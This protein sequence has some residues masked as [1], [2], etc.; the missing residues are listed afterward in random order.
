M[1]RAK[2]T[3]AI[4]NGGRGNRKLLVGVSLDR[5]TYAAV[6]ALAEQR[7][8]SRSLWCSNAI[9]MALARATAELADEVE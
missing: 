5:P 3:S 9:K 4:S 1:A 2:N 8:E 7:N 6:S